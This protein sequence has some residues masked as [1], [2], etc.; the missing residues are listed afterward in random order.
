VNELRY[1]EG[2]VTL[3]LDQ[4]KCN[5]CGMCVEVCPHEVY[6]IEDRKAVIV[7]RDACMECGACAMNCPVEAIQVDAGVGCATAVITGAIRG[8]EPTC[9]CDEDPSCCC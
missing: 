2:V 5:G 9:G 1:L 6:T 8:T 7:D 4:G 3:E